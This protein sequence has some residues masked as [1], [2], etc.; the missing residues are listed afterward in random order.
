MVEKYEK[1]AA[2]CPAV[3]FDVEFKPYSSPKITVVQWQAYFDQ[4][5]RKLGSTRREFKEVQLVVFT[6]K[7]TRVAYAF[8]LPGNPAHPAWI[9]RRVSALGQNLAIEQTGYFAGDERSFAELLKRYDGLMKAA[10]RPP[11]HIIVGSRLDLSG[12][13]QLILLDAKMYRVQSDGRIEMSVSFSEPTSSKPGTDERLIELGEICV[14]YGQTL[15]EEAV[16][17]AYRPRVSAF[18]PLYRTPTPDESGKL[19][20]DGFSF[21]VNNGMCTLAAPFPTALVGEV[22]RRAATKLPQ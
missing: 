3:V 22:L 20:D 2:A 10:L 12:G 19:S 5:Q 15:I 18:A 16:P 13:R 4:V 14:R 11:R 9:T 8:T 7:E 1:Y 21:R 17:F 6:D